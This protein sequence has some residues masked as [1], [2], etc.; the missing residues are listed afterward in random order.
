MKA[1]RAEFLASGIRIKHLV[2]DLE[3]EAQQK[4]HSKGQ[5]VG[6]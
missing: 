6:H 2:N 1:E 4:S 3:T 5:I